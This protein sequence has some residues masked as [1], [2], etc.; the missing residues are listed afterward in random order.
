LPGSIRGLTGRVL[1][2]DDPNL[3]SFT[4]GEE[5]LRFELRDYEGGTRLVLINELPP[6]RPR[7]TPRAGMRAW[8]G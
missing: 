6:R 8:T 2:V 7:A 1:A 3:L 4:R 5:A